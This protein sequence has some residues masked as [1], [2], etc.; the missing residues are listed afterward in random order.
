MVSVEVSLLGRPTAG[1]SECDKRDLHAIA[2]LQ[3]DVYQLGQSARDAV[4]G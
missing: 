4:S 2:A 1:T 3:L